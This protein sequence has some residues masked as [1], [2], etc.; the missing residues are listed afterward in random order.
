MH[1]AGHGFST[2]GLSHGMPGLALDRKNQVI[3]AA[4]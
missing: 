2:W 1:G 3:E 4:L